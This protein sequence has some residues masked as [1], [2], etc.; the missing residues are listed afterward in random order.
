MAED[1]FGISRIV[2]VKVDGGKQMYKVEWMSTWEPA[3]S[4]LS[5]QHLIDNFWSHVNNA[6]Q[7][8]H[9][10][11][12]QQHVANQLHAAQRRKIKL[13]SSLVNNGG[14]DMTSI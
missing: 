13:E 12:Q 5:C 4:L 7:R 2:D 10:A 9:V 3:E 14:H 11:M 8:Q 1:S 6:K